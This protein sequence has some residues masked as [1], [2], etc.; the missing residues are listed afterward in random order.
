MHKR[1]AF[2]MHIFIAYINDINR[3]VWRKSLLISIANSDKGCNFHFRKA[4]FQNNNR[5]EEN[6]CGENSRYDVHVSYFDPPYAPWRH[7]LS[8]GNLIKLSPKSGLPWSAVGFIAE[9]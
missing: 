2:K 6:E 8:A 4:S 7:F 9:S 5:Q 3:F 1:K